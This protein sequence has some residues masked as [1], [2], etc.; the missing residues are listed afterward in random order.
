MKRIFAVAFFQTHSVAKQRM[1]ERERERE[2]E[3]LTLVECECKKK[4]QFLA[5]S[6]AAHDSRNLSFFNACLERRHV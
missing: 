1:R 6:L 4:T 3:R 5:N 2:R